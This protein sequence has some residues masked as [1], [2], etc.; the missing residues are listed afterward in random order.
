MTIKE[1]VNKKRDEILE[2][3][4][5]SVAEEIRHKALAAIFAGVHSAEW[6]DLMMLFAQTPHQL[7]RL[8]G[9]DGT[10]DPTRNLARAYLV[11]SAL[12]G[13]SNVPDIAFYLESLDDGV[14]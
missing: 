12:N 6:V 1:N 13:L 3:P 4:D 5:G 8:V 10:T 14:T 9:T 2:D 11:S 7:A